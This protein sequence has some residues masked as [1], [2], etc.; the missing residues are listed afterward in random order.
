LK[1][2][3]LFLRKSIFKSDSIFIRCNEALSVFLW[4]SFSK[5]Y[6]D[7]IEIDQAPLKFLTDEFLTLVTMINPSLNR[8]RPHWTAFVYQLA[9]FR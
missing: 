3:F 2:G 4:D 6:L 9:T 1:R 5:P 7:L 8:T